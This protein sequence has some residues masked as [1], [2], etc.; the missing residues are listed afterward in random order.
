MAFWCFV[1]GRVLCRAGLSQ[2]PPSTANVA[3]SLLLS[4]GHPISPRRS[5]AR[6]WDQPSR[7]MTYFITASLVFA[8]TSK[9][10]TFHCSAG[11][12]RTEAGSV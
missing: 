1:V 9:L 11:G 4:F 7:E 6:S 8:M 2:W 5:V 3:K 12:P 10:E